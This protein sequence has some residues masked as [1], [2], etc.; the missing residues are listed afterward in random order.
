MIVYV[1]RNKFTQRTLSRE[2]LGRVLFSFIVF[3]HVKFV[4]IK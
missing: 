1:I 4:S 3:S 2:E